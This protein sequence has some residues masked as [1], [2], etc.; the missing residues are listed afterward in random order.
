MESGSVLETKYHQKE[1]AAWQYCEYALPLVSRTFALNINVLSGE[2]KRAVLLGYLVCRFLDT[3][4]DDHNLDKNEKADLLR[5]S[6]LVFKTESLRNS[7]NLLD[8][9][10]DVEGK[11]EELELL[12]KIEYLLIA[13]KSLP[14]EVR[15][16]SLATYKEMS[17]GM[18]E[19]ALRFDAKN[20]IIL[21]DEADLERYCYYVAGTVG[22]FLKDIFNFYY[23]FS[24]ETLVELEKHA[25]AFGLGLQMT[26]ISKDIIQDR[27]RG[28]T[29]L[30]QT[31]LDEVN[32]T[33]EEFIK[34]EKEELALLALDKLI[35]KASGHLNSALT[36]TLLLPNSYLRL[37]LFCLWPLWMAMKTLKTI[38]GNYQ[39]FLSD[40][41]VKIT[42]NEVK[43]ILIKTSLM[44]PFNSILSKSFKRL[45]NSI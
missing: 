34:G 19:Y 37:R 6:Y 40:K 36:F 25:V 2:T 1:L 44:A 43:K 9:L 11:I 41:D 14:E 8:R 26:N 21:K 29:F 17:E 32:I 15:K 42:R 45:E 3:I 4:E 13:H 22:V 12:S 39:V 24:K 31:Y 20:G 5:E 18:S 10:M 38:K 7:S 35:T 30:P 27:K 33:R 23:N 16:I 28:W